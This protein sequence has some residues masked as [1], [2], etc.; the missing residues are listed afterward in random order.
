MLTKTWFWKYAFGIAAANNS[1]LVPVCTQCTKEKQQLCSSTCKHVKLVG[2]YCTTPRGLC[3]IDKKFI[4]FAVASLLHMQV[5]A[6]AVQ[7]KV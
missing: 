7:L 5:F 4:F 6:F 2:Y 3:V 1:K